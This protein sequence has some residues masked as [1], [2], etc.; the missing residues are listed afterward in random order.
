[1]FTPDKHK[2]KDASDDVASISSL[3]TV[4][5]SNKVTQDTQRTAQPDQVSFRSDE[6]DVDSVTV[7]NPANIP[8]AR[9]EV[10]LDVGKVP[11]DGVAGQGGNA[12]AAAH[13]G[14]AGQ[15]GNAKAVGEGGGSG[16][17]VVANAAAQGA[18]VGQDGALGQNEV[19]AVNMYITTNKGRAGNSVSSKSKS[20]SV[21]DS[22]GELDADLQATLAQELEELKRKAKKEQR[23]RNLKK[24]LEE[25]GPKK[26]RKDDENGDG[27]AAGETDTK[28]AAT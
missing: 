6:K 3:T 7:T 21:G 23:R 9:P 10:V 24:F 28:P 26:R 22:D 14:V 25:N 1:M 2:E 5:V 11:Q 12:N 18:V 19:S 15:G 27:N 20:G 16:G 13:G 8:A 17:M 4:Q